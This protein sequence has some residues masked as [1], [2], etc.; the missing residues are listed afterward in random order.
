LQRERDRLK[1]EGA[2]LREE[3]IGGLCANVAAA[4]AGNGTSARDLYNLLTRDPAPA[5]APEVIYFSTGVERGLQARVDIDRM[6]SACTGSTRW[7][8]VFRWNNG[9]ASVFAHVPGPA[10]ASAVDAP[11]ASVIVLLFDLSHFAPDQRTGIIDNTKAMVE[12]RITRTAVGLA[13]YPLFAVSRVGKTPATLEFTGNRDRVF[14]A[15]DKMVGES[16]VPTVTERRQSYQ[17]VCPQIPRIRADAEKFLNGDS[18]YQR[19]VQIGSAGAWNPIASVHYWGPDITTGG[20]ASSFVLS[21]KEACDTPTGLPSRDVPLDARLVSFVTAP[22]QARPPNWSTSLADR[23]SDS[24]VTVSFL[25]PLSPGLDIGY[26]SL[27]VRN[28]S[29][30]RTIRSITIVAL[31]TPKGGGAVQ[32]FSRPGR[33]LRLVPGASTDIASAIIDNPSFTALGAQG[34]SAVVGVAS[35]EFEDGTTWTSDFG[36]GK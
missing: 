1:R 26:V 7:R 30:T 13:P 9:P 6:A 27:H 23:P 2:V 31:V 29:P 33:S 3:A 17:A 19:M 12:Q 24:P 28:D 36:R 8:L 18:Q 32:R 14:A 4:Q 10:D 20:G 35:V 11:N 5:S 16:P 21:I 15:L 22:G 25:S 34:A